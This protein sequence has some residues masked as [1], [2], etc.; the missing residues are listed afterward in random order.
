MNRYANIPII[1]TEEDPKRRYVTT[2][3]PEIPL[4]FSDIYVYTTRGDRY[5]TLAL[6]Y[7]GD[8]SLWWVIT[9]ANPTE[10]PDSLIPNY[11]AQIR[12]PAISRISTILSEY[13]SLNAQI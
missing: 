2:K 12:I 11:G 6:S 1:K 8:P 13:N 5:D 3:Y 7:Y 4:D 9:R 10:S